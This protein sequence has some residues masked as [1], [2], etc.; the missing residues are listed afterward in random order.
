MRRVERVLGRLG[1]VPDPRPC[2]SWVVE[3][4]E[5]RHVEQR[6]VAVS[7]DPRWGRLAEVCVSWMLW[8]TMAARR[9]VRLASMEVEWEVREVLRRLR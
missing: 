1:V 9:C 3:D 7:P 4:D 8:R 6:C 5:H 2:G